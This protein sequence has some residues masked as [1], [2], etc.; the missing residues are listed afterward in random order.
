M[1]SPHQIH[2]WWDQGEQNSQKKGM[3]CWK[4]KVVNF[5]HAMSAAHWGPHGGHDLKEVVG[6]PC[7]PVVRTLHS[8]C[9]G[10][11]V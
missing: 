4:G 1:S 3:G 7:G 2:A 9:W 10:R 6:L 11:R 5:L 8:Q